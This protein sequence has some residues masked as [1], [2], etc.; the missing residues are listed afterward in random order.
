MKRN[1]N[2]EYNP[3]T[4]EEGRKDNCI[5]NTSVEQFKC[6]L[7]VYIKQIFEIFIRNR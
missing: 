5:I 7:P 6:I 2:E 4:I 1:N 3:N